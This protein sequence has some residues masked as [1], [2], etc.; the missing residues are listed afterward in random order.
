MPSA[1]VSA[2]VRRKKTKQYSTK[3]N[4]IYTHRDR[5]RKNAGRSAQPGE[6]VCEHSGAFFTADAAVDGGVVPVMLFKEI[7]HTAA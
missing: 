6:K 2:D 7:D 4:S 1:Q 3:Q 5:E